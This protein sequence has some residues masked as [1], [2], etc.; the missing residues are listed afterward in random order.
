MRGFFPSAT[1][2]IA[3]L[4]AAGFNQLRAAELLLIQNDNLRIRAVQQDE[5]YYLKFDCRQ[6]DGTWRTVLGT[7][8]Q[9]TSAPWDKNIYAVSEDPHV[10]WRQGSGELQK[11]EAFFKQAKVEAGGQAL[12]LSGEVGPHQIE[13]R[14]TL[15]GG[16]RLYITVTDRLVESSDPVQLGQL[17]SHFY[18]LPDDQSFGYAIPLEFAWLPNLHRDEAGICGDHFF[19]SPA[20]IAFGKG[21]YAAIVPDLEPLAQQR[22]IPHALDLRVY[23]AQAEVPRLSYG[24]STW[25]IEGHVYTR[26]DLEH[27]EPVQD[28][29]LVYGF[30]L[31][32]GQ[33]EGPGEV[34]TQL[35]SHLWQS[36]GHKYF[37]D[38]RPQVMPFEEYGR[39]YSYVHELQRWATKTMVDAQEAFGIKDDFKRGALFHAW[40]NDL[41]VGFGVWH[42]GDK[43]RNQELKRIANGIMRLSLAAPRKEGAF[44]CVYNFDEGRYEG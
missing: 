34:T 42:Y 38:I 1:V 12:V 26:H 17:M 27:T 3:L 6:A 36:Y 2:C 32:W 14:L 9:A 39:R 7:L 28:K 11:A 21:L 20:V 35:T 30:D 22:A 25:R 19:R 4:F 37:Q 43:W 16:N 18:F 5:R 8:A 15:K 40:W 31:F 23:G 10:E 29:Q 33:A 24:L 13:Q 41:H 44:P